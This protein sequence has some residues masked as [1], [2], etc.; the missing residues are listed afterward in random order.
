MGVAN[1][2]GNSKINGAGFV[3]A[4]HIEGNQCVRLT[5]YD[6]SLPSGFGIRWIKNPRFAIRHIFRGS[7]IYRESAPR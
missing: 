2:S 5:I 3:S 6:K 7:K 4:V 1:Q